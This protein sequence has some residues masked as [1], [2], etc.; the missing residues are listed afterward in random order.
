MIV[1][2]NAL[3]RV[4]NLKN[5]KVNLKIQSIV[6]QSHDQHIIWLSYRIFFV[7]FYS[8][9]GTGLWYRL[10]HILIDCSHAVCLDTIHCY[11]NHSKVSWSQGIVPPYVT[12]KWYLYAVGFWECDQSSFSYRTFSIRSLE[13][14]IYFN[15]SRVL[16]A[17]VKAILLSKVYIG[18]LFN[19]Q[20]FLRKFTTFLLHNECC[21]C[22]AGHK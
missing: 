8:E 11:P 18:N 15:L 14:I 10:Y 13:C 2:M 16:K 1:R 6:P 3:W 4:S 22:N 12:R 21:L 20:K 9:A 19:R 5:E 7:R 17:R